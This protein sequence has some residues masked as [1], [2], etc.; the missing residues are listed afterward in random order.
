[1]RPSKL[2]A[3]I[4]PGSQH[5]GYAF[6]LMQGLGIPPKVIESGVIDAGR[7]DKA[8]R[9]AYIGATFGDIFRLKKP[10]EVALESGYV[11]FGRARGCLTLAE[12]R[13]VIIAVA[14]NAGALVYEYAPSVVKKAVTGN[15]AAKKS[16]MQLMTKALFQLDRVPAEDEAD[17]L[18]IA[19]THAMR[20]GN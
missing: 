20:E 19:F 15:G 6:V 5:V 12:S 9:L 7:Q 16:S 8:D 1:M 18:G 10:V 14:V 13:G 4:D 11:M 3:G 17:A 2:I